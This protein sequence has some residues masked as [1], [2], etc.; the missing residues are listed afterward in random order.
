MKQTNK[1]IEMKNATT[2]TIDECLQE[3]KS[4]YC[5]YELSSE[6][7]VWFRELLEIPECLQWYI[8]KCKGED[9]ELEE[10]RNCAMMADNY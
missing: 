1:E 2:G 7:E 4:L 9:R 5:V 10:R 3:L 8:S 6:Q